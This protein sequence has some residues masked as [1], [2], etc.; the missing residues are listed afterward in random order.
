MSL[1][2]GG[3]KGLCRERLRSGKP[4]PLPLEDQPDA[5]WCLIHSQRRHSASFLLRVVPSSEGGK[6]DR[7]CP[8][9]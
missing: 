1:A 9:P 8:T 7:L 2:F 3:G 5:G 4:Y 6:E